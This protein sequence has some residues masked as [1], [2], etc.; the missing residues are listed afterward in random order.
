[1]AFERSELKNDFGDPVGE[2]RSCR[3]ESALFDFSFLECAK[4][5][6]P[7]ARSVVEA[8]VRRP[9]ATLAQGAI[10]YA[11]RTDPYGTSL[12]D[13]TVWRTGADAF[14][15]M[16][17]RREDILELMAGASAQVETT[18]L[19]EARVVF[20]VQ[21]PDALDVL[22]TLGRLKT[23][24]DLGYF[25]F[26]QMEL[27]GVACTVG[28]L[29][30]TG[31]AGFEIILPRS[32]SSRVWREFAR[33]SRPAGFIAMDTLRIEAGFVLFANEF[34]LP[35]APAELGLQQ[36]HTDRNARA[37][38]LKL[39]CFQAKADHLSLP[40]TGRSLP[41]RP[42]EPGVIAITSVCN[43]IA[44]GGILG[45]GFITASTADTDPLHDPTGEFQEI[46]QA[47]LPFYDALKRRP[48]QP[49]R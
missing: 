31:E 33:H 49:W 12:A 48:R 38:G 17:G 8:F 4:L 29:G 43:S 13:L 15:V 3:K 20:A 46:R 44:A 9:L 23:I 41:Q 36:F 47:P 26:M 6:G 25:R 14:E 10:A 35:V 45:L 28:R 18:D 5:Q 19:G 2:A 22:R 7:G 27:S 21:G 37:G 11:I 1:M 24:A 32:E 40:W 42:V 34:R 30:Y 39:V 16:S